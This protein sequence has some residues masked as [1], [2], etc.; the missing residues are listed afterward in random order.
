MSKMRSLNR[1][2]KIKLKKQTRFDNEIE[3]IIE[4]D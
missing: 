1:K 4:N 2:E 3:V